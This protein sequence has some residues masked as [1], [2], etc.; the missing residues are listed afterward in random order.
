MTA[1]MESAQWRNYRGYLI[2]ARKS[3]LG[4][5]RY[6]VWK[7]RHFVGTFRDGVVAEIHIDSLVGG[8]VGRH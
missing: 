8:R 5:R 7:A 3:F 2:L 4:L 6:D 1:V